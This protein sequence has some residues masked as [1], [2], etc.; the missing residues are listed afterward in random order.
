[1][2]ECVVI[3]NKEEILVD[4]QQLIFAGKAVRMELFC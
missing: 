4:Q 3:Q 1:M 2:L